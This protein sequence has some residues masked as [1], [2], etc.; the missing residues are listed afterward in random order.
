MHFSIFIHMHKHTPVPSQHYALWTRF[1]T[2][3]DAELTHQNRS[4]KQATIITQWLKVICWK[5]ETAIKPSSLENGE[6]TQM[7]ALAEIEANWGKTLH[8][9]HTNGRRNSLGSCGIDWLHIY[10]A[11]ISDTYRPPRAPKL[12]PEIADPKKR[13]KMP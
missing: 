5:G 9:L 4:A 2:W 13:Q 11:K 8:Y 7:V 1:T 6:R 12:D 3:C 10:S